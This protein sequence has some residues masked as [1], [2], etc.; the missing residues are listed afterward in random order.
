[1]SGLVVGDGNGDGEMEIYA[2]VGMELG[3]PPDMGIH[4]FKWDGIQWAKTTISNYELYEPAV[5]DGNYDGEMEVYAATGGG[6]VYQFKPAFI[7]DIE[8]AETSH[9]FGSVPIGDSLDWEY[10]VIRNVGV[11]TLFIDSLLSDTAVF[12]VAEPT[13]PNTILS[14]DTTLVTIRFKPHVTDTVSGTLKE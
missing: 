1:M 14:D 4:Y 8:L 12:V 2:T 10:L 6:D 11:D 9:D 13:F 3:Y 5:G 7:P